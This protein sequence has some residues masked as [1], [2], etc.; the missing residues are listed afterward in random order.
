MLQ[1]GQRFK[2]EKV[3]KIASDPNQ[4]CTRQH[5]VQET[6]QRRGKHIK[7][8]VILGVSRFCV[9]QDTTVLL[10]GT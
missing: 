9:S 1:N 8:D 10:I 4:R 3:S 5:W 7:R 6:E 2:R